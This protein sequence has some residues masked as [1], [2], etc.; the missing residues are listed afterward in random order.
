MIE[1]AK[2]DVEGPSVAAQNPYAPAH[3]RVSDALATVAA[4]RRDLYLRALAALAAS[5]MIVPQEDPT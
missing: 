1:P 5:D 4:G 3:Q 2:S